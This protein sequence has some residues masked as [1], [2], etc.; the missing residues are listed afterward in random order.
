[1]QPTVWADAAWCQ[2]AR[3][4]PPAA[5]ASLNTLNQTSLPGD[6]WC[7][8]IMTNPPEFFS[9]RIAV[10]HKLRMTPILGSVA[11][12]ARMIYQID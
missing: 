11:N 5:L 4:N 9:L 2:N 12:F 10:P 8:E 6:Q 3:Y 1:M 7:F